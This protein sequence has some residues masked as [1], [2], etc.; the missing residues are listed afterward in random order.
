[1]IGQQ[2]AYVVLEHDLSFSRAI[3]LLEEARQQ[4]DFLVVGLILPE[5]DEDEKLSSRDRQLLQSY[6]AL[7]C[8]DAIF[9]FHELQPSIEQR[10]KNICLTVTS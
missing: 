2:V 1:M 6:A 7:G 4:A 9:D 8:V 10:L 3:E 5:Q